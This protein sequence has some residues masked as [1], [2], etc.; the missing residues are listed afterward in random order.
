M[1]TLSDDLVKEDF[2]SPGICDPP[3]QAEDRGGPLVSPSAPVGNGCKSILGHPLSGV[4]GE[5]NHR[6]A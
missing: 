2:G 5:Q 4:W 3:A 1:P 6:E